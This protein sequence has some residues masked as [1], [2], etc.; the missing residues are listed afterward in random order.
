[1]NKLL[2]LLHDLL[3]QLSAHPQ[4]QLA[5]LCAQLDPFPDCPDNADDEPLLYL[6]AQLR[7][8]VP[9][10][11]A[12]AVA[13]WY[14]QNNLAQLETAL[15][16]HLQALGL[17]IEQP[18]DALYGVPMPA[19]GIPWECED[20]SEDHPDWLAIMALFGVDPLED[21]LDEARKLAQLVFLTLEGHA[22]PQ[23]QQIGC[24]V[25]FLF[26]TTGN[27][28]VDFSPEDMSELVPLDWSDLAFALEI[29]EEAQTIMAQARAGL[30]HL[31]DTSVQK[32]LSHVITL[33]ERALREKGSYR[34]PDRLAEQLRPRLPALG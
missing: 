19:W 32:W 20:W 5:L 26:S 28:T 7:D 29:I 16:R 12:E 10:I 11:Y 4:T 21:E 24:A 27:S 3:R 14:E 33:T 31:Q 9:K 30:E 1:M 18:E 6:I 8:Y 17:P 15:C 13:L 22:N 23:I 34:E 2:A 25:G